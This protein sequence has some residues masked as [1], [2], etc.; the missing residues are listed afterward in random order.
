M[1]VM[2]QVWRFWRMKILSG[3]RS[4]MVYKLWG[5]CARLEFPVV[6]LKDYADRWDALDQS[7][8]PF[9]VTMMTHLK[10]LETRLIL[11]AC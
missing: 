6:K 3:V 5:S 9:G 1:I 8:N 11:K 2:W 7:K 4:A 10:A